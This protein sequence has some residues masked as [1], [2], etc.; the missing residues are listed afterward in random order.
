MEEESNVV[1]EEV[2]Q[3]RIK[4]VPS[5][6]SFASLGFVASYAEPIEMGKQKL[7]K[8]ILQAK[9]SNII[10]NKMI[11]ESE[12][13]KGTMK[14]TEG[15]TEREREGEREI[16]TQL[17]LFPSSSVDDMMGFT[18]PSLAATT[19]ADMTPIRRNIQED[20]LS[21]S[22]LISS[23]EFLSEKSILTTSIVRVRSGSIK[24]IYDPQ[25]NPTLTSTSTC[26]HNSNVPGDDFAHVPSLAAT[27]DSLVRNLGSP[28]SLLSRSPISSRK[29][30]TTILHPQSGIIENR[31]GS[32]PCLSRSL[33]CNNDNMT[34]SIAR[35]EAFIK[36]NKE[37]IP[38]EELG[39][40]IRG[41]NSEIAMEIKSRLL[42]TPTKLKKNSATYKFNSTEN[43]Y[44]SLKSNLN[45][46]DD[47]LRILPVIR[48]HSD[49]VVFH[50]KGSEFSVDN[51]TFSTTTNLHSN[52]SVNT[53]N[54]M[55]QSRVE[56]LERV[57]KMSANSLYKKE[58]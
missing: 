21:S 13:R 26:V 53:I 28:K 4:P 29:S 47:F 23:E 44:Q 33:S 15:E 17:L 37:L 14:E 50:R 11:T 43:D 55:I 7:T 35:R 56:D 31:R 3:P 42:S 46:D 58:E 24:G 22:S 27:I 9:N 41:Y 54:P 1:N 51:S 34:V 2:L 38:T 19:K 39:I 20:F 32:T 30:S 10:R 49:A 48:R 25:Q 18:S 52:S 57:M 6:N 45:N 16:A 8:P 12:I 36:L 40:D 5:C